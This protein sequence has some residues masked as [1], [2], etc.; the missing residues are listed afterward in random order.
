MKRWGTRGLTPPRGPCVAPTGV[1][2]GTALRMYSRSPQT[3]GEEL[4][5]PGSSTFHLMLLVSLHASG[6]LAWIETPFAFGPRH[7]GQFRSAS[8][9]AA[10]RTVVRSAPTSSE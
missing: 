3:I 8:G 4:P 2:E 7:C 10:R 9:E 5:R 6:G 1:F